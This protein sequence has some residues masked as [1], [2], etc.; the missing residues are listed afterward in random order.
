M[1]SFEFHGDRTSGTSSRT[2]L[3][4][5]RELNPRLMEG[6]GDGQDPSEMS[7][8]RLVLNFMEI[9]HQEPHQELPYPPSWSLILD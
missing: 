8:R 9:G 2:T 5:I 4:S 1:L 7:R 6:S 3:S